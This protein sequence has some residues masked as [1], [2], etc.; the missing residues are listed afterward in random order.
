MVHSQGAV[1]PLE[2]PRD[3][4]SRDARMQGGVIGDASNMASEALIDPEGCRVEVH[5]VLVRRLLEGC[6]KSSLHPTEWV[7]VG[8]ASSIVANPAL[9]S[10]LDLVPQG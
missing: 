10:I 7:P 3:A 2:T 4:A 1:G 9:A 6:P 8:L 5:R